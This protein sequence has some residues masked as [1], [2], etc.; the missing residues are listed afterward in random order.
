M[1]LSRCRSQPTGGGGEYFGAHCRLRMLFF[2]NGDPPKSFFFERKNSFWVADWIV[3]SF[4]LFEHVDFVQVG[5][6]EK[7][8]KHG[9]NWVE[10][11]PFESQGSQAL[12]LGE[13]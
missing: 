9:R 8:Q 1:E 2:Y 5:G 7:Q 6:G 13:F 4:G 12:C 3:L 10:M 11:K